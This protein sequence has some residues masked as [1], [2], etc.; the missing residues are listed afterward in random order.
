M[1]FGTLMSVLATIAPVLSTAPV[2][3]DDPNLAGPAMYCVNRSP[4]GTADYSPVANAWIHD[5]YHI[6]DVLPRAPRGR[7]PSPAECAEAWAN[8]QG[9]F[10]GVLEDDFMYICSDPFP[11]PRYGFRRLPPR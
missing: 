9:E 5:C 6:Y 4:Y 10:R 1:R 3:A 11:D 7:D 2:F 8:H